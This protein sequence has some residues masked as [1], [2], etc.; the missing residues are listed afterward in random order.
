V[1]NPADPPD[2]GLPQAV[3]DAIHGMSYDSAAESFKSG[4]TKYWLFLERKSG[5]IDVAQWQYAM[6]TEGGV[7]PRGLINAATYNVVHGGSYDPANGTISYQGS[8]YRIRIK[9]TSTNK[10]YAEATAV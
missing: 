4:S 5:T 1:P 7:N 8:N 10:L 6:D 2:P 3:F 9:R